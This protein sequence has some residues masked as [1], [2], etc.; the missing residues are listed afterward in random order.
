VKTGK[1]KVVA[2]ER[3][4]HACEQVSQ[5]KYSDTVDWDE[6]IVLALFFLC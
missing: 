3:D 5:G 2:Q 1:A 6:T 4:L